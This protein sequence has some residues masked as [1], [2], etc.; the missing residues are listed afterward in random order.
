MSQIKINALLLQSLVFFGVL[1]DLNQ[2]QKRGQTHFMKFGSNA[3]LQIIETSVGPTLLHLFSYDRHLDTQK[4]VAFAV[5]SFARLEKAGEVGGLLGIL[6]E[7]D[8]GLEF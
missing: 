3:S 8:A 2:G 1:E 6:M 5:L 7:K 4:L